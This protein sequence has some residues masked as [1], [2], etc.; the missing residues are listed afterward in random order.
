MDYEDSGAEDPEKALEPD[1]P[2]VEPDWGDNL[3]AVATSLGDPDK[4]FADAD[5]VVKGVVKSAGSRV[6]RSSPAG[7]VASGTHY[8]ETLT[9]WDSTQAPHAVRMCLA[10]TLA[11]QDVDPR[12]P[13][14]RRRIR[15]APTFGRSP[16]RLPLNEV[17]RPV[18]WIETRAEN[19]LVGGH[20]RD[21]SFRYQA[22]YKDDGELTGIRLDVIADVGAPSALCGWGMSFVTWYCLPCVYK[23][24]NSETHLRSV[25]TN[26]CPWNAYRGYGKDAASLLMERS[27]T[28][29]RRRRG[30][31]GLRSGSA[32]SSNPRSF[33]IPRSPAPCSTAATTRARCARR[34]T[35]STTRASAL[36]EQARQEGR[37]IGLGIAM[38]LT[39]EGCSM[40]GSLMLNGTDSTE[41]RITPNGN[42]IVL[43]GVTSRAAGTRPDRADRRRR[44]PLRH[45]A[46]AWFR[47]T[48]RRA[49]GASAARSRSIIIGG[50]AGQVAG[51]EI[52]EKMRLVA[53]NMLEASA[54]DVEVVEERFAIRGSPASVGVTFE[55]VAREVYS[56]PHG[57]NMDGVEPMLQSVRQWKM[58][59]VSPARDAGT[60][61][62]L[63]V[64]AVRS[65][66]RD[67]RGRPETGHVKILRYCLV[68][69]AGTIVN[70]LLV[71]AN[72]HGGIAQG[73]GGAMF[74]Q[75]AYDE[76]GQPLTATFMDYTLPTAVELPR[77]EIG[78]Q[79]TP[80]PF[81]PLGTK[82]VGESG[83][84][85]ARVA[86]QCDRERVARGQPASIRATMTPAGSGRRSR[87]LPPGPGSRLRPEMLAADFEFHAP[88]DLAEEL[89]LLVEKGRE[90]RS[91]RRD[92]H[93]PDRQPRPAA[94]RVCRLAQPRGRSGFRRRLR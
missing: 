50:S 43:T 74:E 42:V 36:Q 27:W 61:Q 12:H 30:S 64:V 65:R 68:E 80:A 46:S 6:P 59:N 48:P 34:W 37:R 58:P 38:E 25:V 72:L 23:C 62:R 29:S 83:V 81:T 56:N 40:P 41:V 19:L 69:D 82:G 67:R 26:K 94:P 89:Q 8:K 88:T 73:I 33:R 76:A 15:E 21:T 32:T 93:G 1:A 5:G 77:L 11:I 66:G 13:A 4:A 10:K 20:A 57:K 52:H 92:E 60:V 22:A 84:G 7:I 2:L 16:V 51:E 18:K 91:C 3:M 49:H 75:I 79:Q 53:A 71:D 78:H 70:P 9:F 35:W 55:E 44:A 90:R 39:P 31:T 45:L 63:P 24:E 54:D 14:A 87:T 86:L 47:A 85:H 17:G 28:T